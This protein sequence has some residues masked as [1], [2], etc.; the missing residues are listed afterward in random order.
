MRSA[1]VGV[2]SLP[3]NRCQ[4]AS[5]GAHRPAGVA[6]RRLNPDVGESAVAQHLA[7]GDAIER[8]AAGEAEIGHFVLA[9]KRARE[10]QDHVLGDGLN[11]GG[12]VHVKVREQI[13]VRPPHRLSEQIG[14]G[15]VRH[16]QADAIVEILHVEMERAVVLEEDEL[17]ENEIAI[18]RL[19]IRREAHQLVLARIHLEPRVIGE[20]GIKEAER[21]REMQLLVNRDVAAASDRNRRRRPLADAVH[22]QD[23]RLVE[24]RRVEGARGMA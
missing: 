8:D 23:H 22:G 18:A 2:R 1:F 10:P 20:G 11:G 3:R 24:R 5:A 4:A 16:G 19:A 9:G 12:H 17:V 14:E 13:L 6:C 7:V 21:V 15:V